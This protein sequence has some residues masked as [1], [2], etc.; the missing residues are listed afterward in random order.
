M[1]K[2][3]SAGKWLSQ[4]LN[5]ALHHS[6]V[7]METNILHQPRRWSWVPLTS[8]WLAFHPS[9]VSLWLVTLSLARQYR[10]YLWPLKQMSIFGFSSGVSSDWLHLSLWLFITH[11]A[12]DR[13]LVQFPG[14]GPACS[15][16][17]PSFARPHPLPSIPIQLNSQGGWGKVQSHSGDRSLPHHHPLWCLIKGRFEN[18]GTC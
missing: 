17:H 18:L 13:N 11:V 9:L 16:L 5:Y 14:S 2:V 15:P 7:V 8:P 3:R 6:T 10:F 4:S 12:P 1:S